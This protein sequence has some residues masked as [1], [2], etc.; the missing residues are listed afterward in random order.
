MSPSW[1]A[2]FGSADDEILRGKIIDEVTT[3]M[4]AALQTAT[5]RSF[6]I[7]RFP[8]YSAGH[9]EPAAIGTI[10]M[11]VTERVEYRSRLET[12]NRDLELI[13]EQ[14][15]EQFLHAKQ[16]AEAATQSKS[17]F[18]AN[19]SH[20]IRTPMNA[21]IGMS[22]L[23]L[24]SDL[25]PRPRN[26]VEKIQQASEHLLHII[27][28]ILDYSKIEAGKLA[29][30][31][32]PFSLQQLVENVVGLIWQK[33]DAK[34]LE[35]LVELDRDL[36]LS[37]LGDALRIGQILTN[38]LT[39]AVKF[40]ETGEVEL[41]V[42]RIGPR[43]DQRHVNICFEVRDTGIG[44]SASALQHLF[45]PFHQV[46]NSSTR[47]FEGTGLGLA[48]CK[49][50]A[51][52]LGGRVA[53]RSSPEI[54]SIFTLELPLEADILEP[55]A[56]NAPNGCGRHVL[57]VDDNKSARNLLA[58]LLRS[59]SFLVEEANSGAQALELIAQTEQHFELILIDW[60]MPHMDGMQTARLIKNHLHTAHAQLI[61]L[62]PHPSARLLDR[63]QSAM[64]SAVIAKP[65]SATA[66][67]EV[68]AALTNPQPNTAPTINAHAQI[69]NADLQGV[70]VLLV[71]DN[72]INCEVAVD[73]LHSF[74]ARVEVAGD[75]AEALRKICAMQ[76][77]AVLM[78]VQ[79]P[80]MD[81]FE[82][83]RN[84]RGNANIPQ[85]PIIAMT[86]NALPGDRERCLE[87]GMDD[88]IAKPIDPNKLL[89]T[90]RRWA[91][92]D[93]TSIKSGG[94]VNGA[95]IASRKQTTPSL[96]AAGDAKKVNLLPYAALQALGL[97]SEKAL[98]LLMGRDEL[99]A[100]VLRR[101]VQER[102]DLP[103]QLDAV[104]QQ[105]D[106]SGAGMLV[107]SLKSLAATIGADTLQKICA[108]LEQEFG[109]QRTPYE[110]IADF[111][112]EIARLIDAL[113][114]LLVT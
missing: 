114:P 103:Q 109:A 27:N 108:E 42:Y 93:S 64:F 49:Q 63:E 48:I 54:G 35:V 112:R 57:I 91:I 92:Q 4:P 39:N 95:V 66:L 60:K 28:D 30:E 56:L 77:D 101:F 43:G 69:D 18:L 38:F 19:M 7:V 55:P 100:K 73:I 13:V 20:E 24:N 46:D 9:D 80:V 68:L 32:A 15:T 110:K 47:R 90:L 102:A 59:L 31:K 21:I 78:D 62:A 45:Q 88:Y 12:L 105:C 50:L 22:Y 17:A 70:S 52:L 72:D 71:E 11:N 98:S 104:L 2:F 94:I 53:A 86:A 5:R 61:L 99:Y 40:T 75:G 97:D 33:A 41:C 10:A 67:F 82:A 79:M 96:L 3:E 85:P 107:H 87:A 113:R 16:E 29:L 51:E 14:R 8:V 26:Y 83:T 74:G 44:I 89:E 81:G 37:V 1:A 25:A 34:N 23:A 106:Y 76:F 58:A 65:A 36:P 111:N 6:R 84:I